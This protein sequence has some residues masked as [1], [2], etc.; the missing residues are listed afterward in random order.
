[1][2]IA[3]V[4]S[5]LSFE[6]NIKILKKYAFLALTFGGFSKFLPKNSHSSPPLPP[7]SPSSSVSCCFRGCPRTRGWQYHRKDLTKRYKTKVMCFAMREG[8]VHQQLDVCGDVGTNVNE[9]RTTTAA[10]PT[11][12]RSSMSPFP[13][14]P[15]FPSPYPSSPYQPL[16]TDFI[17]FSLPLSLTN[18]RISLSFRI[19]CYPYLYTYID[20]LYSSLCTCWCVYALAIC[21]IYYW[22]SLHVKYQSKR[23][24]RRA[25]KYL[26]TQYW[27][28]QS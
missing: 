11:L 7:P 21:C 28:W 18:V 3:L 20:L 24:R 26:C 17:Y 25:H 8:I 4:I 9:R 13:S 1:M 16:Y 6:V 2:K 10:P 27:V 22:Y 14:K 23:I 19:L 5:Y 12:F 15:T